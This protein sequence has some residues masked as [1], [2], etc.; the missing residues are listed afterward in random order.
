MAP[1]APSP[2][3]RGRWRHA[4]RRTIVNLRSPR[5][6]IGPEHAVELVEPCVEVLAFVCLD[7]PVGD[8]R[9]LE[10]AERFGTDC[11]RGALVVGVEQLLTTAVELK[12]TSG[13]TRD[14]RQ[15]GSRIADLD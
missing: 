2:E 9:Q 11:G 8:Q 3:L 7:D 1:L 14:A 4:T 15:I 6:G 12:G 10:E 5:T 13:S